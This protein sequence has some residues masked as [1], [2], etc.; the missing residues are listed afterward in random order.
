[1]DMVLVRMLWLVGRVVYVR[2]NGLRSGNGRGGVAWMV[3]RDLP[4][5]AGVEL[6]A[7]P[8]T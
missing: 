5:L 8:I 7:R 4:S 2:R 1:V 3:G 6:C